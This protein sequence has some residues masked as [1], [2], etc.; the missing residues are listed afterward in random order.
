M[1]VEFVSFNNE[2]FDIC[3]TH[4]KNLFSFI[5]SLTIKTS[6][7]GAHVKIA[8]RNQMSY[9]RTA[10]WLRFLRRLN[11]VLI[12]NE[13]CCSLVQSFPQVVVIAFVA[14]QETA[15]TATHLLR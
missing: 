5:N 4:K 13:K 9:R 10:V 6:K 12:G 8:N 14:L 1:T 3:Y 7:N 2:A 15:E 11:G